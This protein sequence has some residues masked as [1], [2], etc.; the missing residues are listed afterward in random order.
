MINYKVSL[1]KWRIKKKHL[2]SKSTLFYKSN[3][4]CSVD[5]SLLVSM[6]GEDYIR[7]FRAD[8]LIHDYDYYV[9]NSN[10]PQINYF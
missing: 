5:Y 9:I 10:S 3:L 2:I 6:N 1:Y 8:T 4:H 7:L